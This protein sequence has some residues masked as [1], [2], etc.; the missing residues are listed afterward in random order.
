MIDSN[1][2]LFIQ[3][4]CLVREYLEQLSNKVDSAYLLRLDEALKAVES[5]AFLMNKP[6]ISKL[7]TLSRNIIADTDILQKDKLLKV[8]QGISKKITEFIDTQNEQLLLVVYE[9][10]THTLANNQAVLKD[11]TDTKINA[12]LQYP[13]KPKLQ[14]DSLKEEVSQELKELF[15]QDAGEHLKALEDGILDLEQGQF[16]IVDIESLMRAAHSYKGASRVVGFKHLEKLAHTLEDFFSLVRRKN[17]NIATEHISVLLQSV[18]ALS[19]ATQSCIKNES[20]PQITPL[21][22]STVDLIKGLI[23]DS[24]QGLEDVGD[25]LSTSELPASLPEKDDSPEA[26]SSPIVTSEQQ[27]TIPTVNKSVNSETADNTIRV[28]AHTLSKMLGLSQEVLINA[29]RLESFA[30]SML[31]LKRDYMKLLSN[32]LRFRE[33]ISEYNLD[34]Y[35]ENLIHELSHQFINCLESTS[36]NHITL[37][38]F[39]RQFIHL[40][41]RLNRE[42][43]KSRMRPF[44]E[45]V[46]GYR[47]LIRDL[48]RSMG[49][50]I[51]LNIEGMHTQ[52][53][54]DILEKLETPLT[55]LVR[56]AVDHGI[57]KTEERL[58]QGKPESGNI[59][60]K[61]FHSAGF[62]SV[63]L[64]DDG[65]G[66]DTIA[67]QKMLIE[68]KLLSAEIAPH[69]SNSELLDFLFLPGFT[70]RE[71]VSEISGRGFGLD[72]VKHMVQQVRG[73]LKIESEVNKFSR[74]IFTLPLTLSM[75]RVL[76]FKVGGEPWALPLLR[77]DRTLKIPASIVK[78]LEGHAYF[79][80]N[81]QYIELLKADE[82]MQLESRSNVDMEN[83]PIIVMGERRRRVALIVEEFLGE[84]QLVLHTLDPL[85]AENHLLASAS[86]LD[87]GCPIMILDADAILNEMSHYFTL[88]MPT[89]FEELG[90]EGGIEDQQLMISNKILLVDDSIMYRQMEKTSLENLG[91]IVDT[92]INGEE[93]WRKLLLDEY[94]LLITDYEMPKLNGF[95]LTEKVR[96]H[97]FKPQI[98]IIIYSNRAE[99]EVRRQ[100]IAIGANRFLFKDGKD[101]ELYS[102]I[103][104]L[105]TDKNA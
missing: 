99:Q 85:L 76:L 86:I 31:S 17:L 84:K 40:T 36:N 51:Q 38:E 71:E 70:T 62:L 95:E 15:A 98:P 90:S 12:S 5:G 43:V 100:A 11:K 18:D 37:D 32:F 7:M 92:A 65:K 53:D 48:S 94:D 66:I 13:K 49:K 105:I 67:L 45:G 27:D 104:Q 81:G 73:V 89:G 1:D 74:F 30:A 77:I 46:T 10:L 29:G 69:L 88:S 35:S 20:D 3:D 103:N 57:E 26:E 21:I 6:A 93:A 79:E 83:I 2:N 23:T 44:S 22:E 68:K 19:A 60:L 56:N 63:I 102:V 33:V 8:L 25:S 39:D 9:D 52:V 50:K 101:R 75:V 87:D 16:S 72:I 78:N 64:E 24:E 47:R 82:F 14:K 61:A 34:E 41:S 80:L 42:V 96:K 54:R 59:Y 4:L 55:Q 58:R 91:F 28:N 97:Y